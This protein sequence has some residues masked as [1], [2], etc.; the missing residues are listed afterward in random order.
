MHRYIS[1]CGG[2]RVSYIKSTNLINQAKQR[3]NLNPYQAR[4]LGELLTT[5]LLSSSLL[6]NDDTISIKIRNKKNKEILITEAGKTGEVRGFIQNIPKIYDKK[7]LNQSI[8][9]QLQSMFRHFRLSLL[10]KYPVDFYCRCSKNSFAKNLTGLGAK[11][12]SEMA[13][14]GTQEIVCHYCSNKYYFSPDDLG[15]LFEPDGSR[16]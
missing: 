13:A 4:F 2:F 16:Q 15:N 11:E 5:T 9:D 12:V 1:D 14:E 3:H 6:K 10:D 8:K 7:N